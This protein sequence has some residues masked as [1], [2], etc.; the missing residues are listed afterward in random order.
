[1]DYVDDACMFMFSEGQKTRSYALFE[2]GGFREN[3][4]VELDGCD[5]AP[6]TNLS[7]ID[8]ST[9][10]LN[11]SWDVVNDAESYEIW[12]NGTIYTSSTNTIELT[13]LDEGI[14]YD[15][16]VVA[17]CANGNPGEYSDFLSVNTLGCFNTPLELTI[18]TDE[19]GAETSWTL[20][21]NGTVVQTDSITYENYTTYTETF[22]FGDGNYEFEIFDS[23]GDGLCC[24]EFGAGSYSLTD[25]DGRTI[26]SGSNF[27]ESESVS[28][29]VEKVETIDC[30]NATQ[31]FE[32]SNTVDAA[33]KLYEFQATED[34]EYIISSVGSTSVNTDLS[35]F[36]SCT[37]KIAENDDFEGL[38]S[39]IS[40]GLSAG[41]IIYINWKDTHSTEGFNWSI[42]S[43]K[44]TQFINFPDIAEK[45]IQDDPF[46]LSATATS[47][48]AITYASSNTDVATISG[49]TVTIHG[50]GQS[51]IS[52]TQLGNEEYLAA[53]DVQKILTVNKMDQSITITEIP[54]KSANDPDF[55]IEASAS[56][57][58]ALSY[59]IIGPATLNNNLV[60][61]DGSTGTV[62][63]TA[64][65]AGNEEYNPASQSISFEVTENPCADLQIS[66]VTT[67]DISCPGEQDG[68]IEVIISGGEAPIQYTLN[69]GAEVDSNL[70]EGLAAGEY[71]I[72]AMDARG[73]SDSIS[74]TIKSPSV[75]EIEAEIANSNSI[76]GNGSI[77]L[78]VTG[79]TGN[80]SYEWSNGADTSILENLEAG[81]YTVIITDENGCS[82]ER[83]F[84]VGG[85]TSNDKLN[86]GE[87]I[88]YPNPVKDY[89][90]LEHSAKIKQISIF[91]SKAQLIQEISLNSDNAE[92]DV[93]A[94]PAGLYFV[95]FNN[96]GK[97]YR[98][99]KE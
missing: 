94:F 33:P 62:T 72:V 14:N 44:L 87:L 91:D 80:Y 27:G 38:Q 7:L 23:A 31:A 97:F 32:G 10:S 19:F 60:S 55:E 69:G 42:T 66:D 56:S 35:I 48:L 86:D 71:T 52:A 95:Q 34:R 83:S 92:I 88:I 12:A 85:V 77:D 65:Q 79:G 30:E 37:V 78:T 54:D 39:E 17:I 53:P 24:G 36:S 73:C 4:G 11:L 75:L 2:S 84:E 46:E 58:L 22:D 6:P 3:L 57:G 51:T 45:T 63:I 68:G 76:N 98:I 16:K 59:E 64:S 20:S 67:T 50:A 81:L 99:I 41:Q 9:S 13:N 40:L 28:F 26:I 47:G 25:K 93:Q 96:K 43:G 49:T 70:W 61:L 89:L 21:L 8:R 15:I 29:C 5:L 90:V 82:L 74:T 1:M 18:N